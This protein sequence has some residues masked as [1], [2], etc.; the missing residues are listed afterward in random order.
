MKSF[1][2][3]NLISD[4]FLGNIYNLSE[5]LTINPENNTEF[6]MFS[7]DTKY[8][9]KCLSQ[10]EFDVFKKIL[11]NYYDYLM[12]C[13]YKNTQKNFSDNRKSVQS[14]T[15]CSSALKSINNTN[16]EPKITFLE[17]IYGL[18]SFKFEEKKI[19]FVIKKNIF[20][21]SN[22]LSITKRYDLK[23]CSVDRKAK[24]KFPYVLKDLDFIESSQKINISSRISSSIFD[25][26]ENDT[27]FLSK[28]NIINYSFYLGI[29]DFPENLEN[30][31]ND[32]GILSSDKSCMYYF[33][34]NDI[35]TEYGKGKVVEH[36]FKKI[37]KGEGISAV[38]PEE[39]KS[40][41]DDFIKS[42]F[43]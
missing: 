30:D 38:P 2:I 31:E 24:S 3:E 17:I 41:F 29:A 26:I 6:I 20:Y 42:C 10:N 18:Y 16:I 7:P 8:L 36:I 9:I 34:I 33:G 15:L 27:L 43:K 19:F 32:E 28:N 4:I 35:F 40:R 25:I 5:L 12:S 1:N 39:Y 37:A 14:S 13:I 11:P 22:N 23:G 21:S